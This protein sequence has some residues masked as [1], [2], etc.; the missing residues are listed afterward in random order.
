MKT[1]TSVRPF[2]TLPSGEEVREITLKN[3]A[4]SCQILTFGGTLRALSVPDRHGEMVDVVLGYDTLEEY[5]A[6]DGYLGAT[7]GRCANRIAKLP[8]PP[9]NWAVFLPVK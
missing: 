4:L 6:R 9:R 7:V 8:P 2:G 5:M 3:E 1:T